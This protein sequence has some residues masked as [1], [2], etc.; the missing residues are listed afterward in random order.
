MDEARHV[1]L[2]SAEKEV[3][4]AKRLEAGDPEARRQLI[5]ANLRLVVSIA[6]RYQGWGLPEDD[7]IQEGNF[8]LMRA[9]EKFDWRRGC[10]FST[11]A[12]WWIRQA[13]LR[14][15]YAQSR[16]VRLPVHAAEQV[17][18]IARLREEL[19]QRLGWEPS[20]RQ[21]AKVLGVAPDD[22]EAILLATQIPASLEASAIE[23]SGE[24][25]VPLSDSTRP[26][27]PEEVLGML[28]QE[29]AASVL[30]DLP[31]REA[32]VLRL[33]LGFHN[34]QRHTL[35]EVGQALGLSRGRVRQIEQEALDRA[36]SKAVALGL[37]DFLD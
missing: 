35:Q 34:G 28:L 26:S 11:Y 6:V 29:Y 14:A 5:E 10:K 9:V 32:E 23:E 30:H 27:P 31:H 22:L 36:R 13:I 16:F 18:R 15:L 1:P 17:S 2:L 24:L 4:L 3:A 25:A 20:T 33:R 8:G 21:V 19:G 12:T 37:H 7:L